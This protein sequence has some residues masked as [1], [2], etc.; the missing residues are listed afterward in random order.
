MSDAQYKVLLVE[1]N[2]VN[3]LVVRKM[4]ERA[5]T[6]RFEVRP[7]GSLVEALDQLAEGGFDAV[8]LDLNL[9]DSAGIE[10]FL[11]IQRNASGLA[12]VILSGVEDEALARKAVE[13]GAQ[14]YLAKT[15]LNPADLVRAL[16]YGI[17]RS[18]KTAEDRKPEPTGNILAF[19]GAKGGV[20]TTTLACHTAREL[21]R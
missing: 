10:T 11:S 21:K 5:E 15:A 6:P 20:G 1:D 2:A 18:R 8:L 4:L 17:I 16:Q 14:D 3:A 12:L 9:P 13:L 19:L 7:A